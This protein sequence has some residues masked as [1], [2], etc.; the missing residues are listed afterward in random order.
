MFDK[1]L[2]SFDY[3]I[4]YLLKHKGDYDII[5]GFISALLTESGYKPVKINALLDGESNKESVDLKRSIADLVVEDV[6]GN[7]YIVEIE[8]AFTLKFMHKACFNSS[9]LVVDSIFGSQD[10]TNIKKVFHISLLYFTT[11]E[12]KKPLYH[13]KTIIHEMDKDHPIDMRIVNQGFVIYE[14]HNVFPE[15]FFISIPSFNDVI[16]SEIDEW[17]YVMKHSD[18]REDFKSPYMNKVSDRLRILKMNKE[19][20]DTYYHYIKKAIQAD[21]TLSAAKIEG[22]KIGLEKGEQIGREK[23]RKE[24]ARLLLQSGVSMEIIVLSTGLSIEEIEKLV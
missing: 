24:V 4:K 19:D 8:R 22:E 17:L 16:K 11:E 3:A 5:E 12:I 10:Y 20:R 13:G 18:V 21:D 15:Y 23:E 7:K 9:R 6:D 2:I 14:H 1:P